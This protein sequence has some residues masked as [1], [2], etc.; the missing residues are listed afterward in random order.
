MFDRIMFLP[1]VNNACFLDCSYCMTDLEMERLKKGDLP[2]D[3]MLPTW[4]IKEMCDKSAG[5]NRWVFSFLGGEPLMN[6]K[7]YFRE[8][9][10]I[11]KERSKFHFTPYS[12]RVTTNGLLLDDEWMDLFAEYNCKVVMSYDGLGNGKKGSKK[13]HEI[14][15]RYANHKA[16]GN[17]AMVVSESN[18]HTLVDVYKELE[19]AG[20]KRFS[21]QYDIFADTPM[22]AKFGHATVELFR[23]IESLEKVTTS[24]FVYNDA[25][26]MKR[27][28]LSSLNSGDFLNNHLVNDYVIDYDGSIR[29]G[30][31]ARTGDM[32]T[33]GNLS[34]YQHINDLLFTKSMRRVLRDYTA[35]L[36]VFGELSEVC[37]MTRGGGYAPDKYGYHPEFAPHIPKLTCYKILLD[38]VS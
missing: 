14:M 2:I 4:R 16:M 9:F 36:Q 34:D 21:T 38:A 1:K 7:D 28:K 33:H 5:F 20:V 24:Y 27:G 10:E 18:Y 26:A 15:K 13:G 17:V 3:T 30:L 6:G 29:N 11:I 32:G 12:T 25:K 8:V 37:R 35:S 22:M 31:S 23:Y 19:S